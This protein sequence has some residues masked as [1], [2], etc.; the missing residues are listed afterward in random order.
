MKEKKKY[1][2]PLLELLDFER[3]DLILTSGESLVEPEEED[4]VPIPIP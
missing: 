4:T 1:G 2:S 3:T